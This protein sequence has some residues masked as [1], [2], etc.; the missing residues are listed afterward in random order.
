MRYLTCFL[1]L[2]LLSNLLDKFLNQVLSLTIVNQVLSLSVI[3]AE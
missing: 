3:N 1:F 2:S